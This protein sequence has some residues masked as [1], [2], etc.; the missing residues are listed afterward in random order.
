MEGGIHSKQISAAIHKC[1][2]Y[3]LLCMR[4][5]QQAM[6]T[7]EEA[8]TH[9]GTANAVA[10]VYAVLTLAVEAGS[11][12]GRHRPPTVHHLAETLA[13]L[14]DRDLARAI[15]WSADVTFAVDPVAVDSIGVPHLNVSCT[16]RI[17]IV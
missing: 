17:R 5:K 12:G 7:R 10:R 4:G 8:S 11:I 14:A 15:G 2:N 3:T 1:S 9:V 16:A 13:R 6:E